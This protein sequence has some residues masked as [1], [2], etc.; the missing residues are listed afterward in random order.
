MFDTT[1]YNQKLWQRHSDSA[2]PPPPPDPEVME[3]A[4]LFWEEHCVECSIPECYT[5]C[6]LYVPRRD[7]KCARFVYG[8]APNREVSGLLPYG[9]DVSFRRWGKLEARLFGTPRLAPLAEVRRYDAWER[10]L[11]AVAN[12]TADV[13]QPVN[14]KR[15]V[16]GLHA[17]LRN[18]WLGRRSIAHS[19]EADTPDAFYVK[20]YNPSTQTLAL[21][22]EF[23]QERLVY[24]DQIPAEPGWNAMTIPLDQL[25]LRPGTPGRILVSPANDEEARFIFTWLDFVRFARSPAAAGSAAPASKVKCV[26]W[27]LDNTLWRGVIG[28]DGADAVQL[29]PAARTLIEQLDERGIVQS[30]AS[31]NTHEVAWAKIEA[32]G[33]Q[34]FFL[35][36]AIHWGPKSRSVQQIADELNINVDTFAVIDDSAFE[37]AEISARL[38]QVRVFDAPDISGLLGRPEFNVAVTEASRMR[39]SSYL[40]EAQRKRVAASWSDDLE[41]FLRSCEMHLRIEVPSGAQR[42]RCL[43]LIARTNQLNLSTRRFTDADLDAVLESSATDCFALSCRDRFGDYGLVGFATVEKGGE[44]P[45]LRDFVLSCRVAE[46]R[47]EEAFVFW[48][49]RRARAAGAER[50]RA[51]LIAT[52]RNQPLRDTLRTLPFS[53]VSEHERTT[54]LEMPLTDSLRQ[55][56][57]ITIETGD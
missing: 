17:F 30:I 5:T 40:V 32:L 14:R 20:L 22:I 36:P 46:K 51:V 12:T 31:K 16:N 53:V 55:P 33:L 24:R 39:R 35:Y 56:D 25:N 38:P 29:N 23:H 27:D 6:R 54:V 11:E 18:H 21:S 15:R 52:D 37:R 57:L 50:L 4:L 19:A 13:L 42:A 26:V 10:R 7:E 34:D 8:I 9:A 28:D 43:E 44:G 3:A 2:L 1:W 45:T 48:Y 47:V 41:G 49:A